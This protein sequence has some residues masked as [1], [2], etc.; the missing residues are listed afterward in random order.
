MRKIIVLGS[1]GMLGQMVKCFFEEKKFEVVCYDDRFTDDKFTGYVNFLNLQESSI[2]INCVG[3]I[4][5]KYDDS[6]SL[7]FANALLPL[8]LARSLKKDHF[9]VHPSTDCVFNGL[10]DSKYL[11]SAN[12]NAEDIYG[13]SKSLGEKAILS[14]PNSLI[15]R[16]SIIGTDSNSKSG[17]LS[18]FLNL[19]PNEV[20]R[21]FNNHYWNGITT[22]EWCEQL[23]DI[24]LKIKNFDKYETEII[25]LGTEKIYSKY[26]MLCLFQKIFETKYIIEKYTNSETINRTLVSDK[27]VIELEEQLNNLKYFSG[28]QNETF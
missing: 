21:G 6:M 3:R 12:H 19:S 22:L 24:L 7:L 14:R 4:K 18:W 1:K 2:I 9:L 23:L 20:L 11:K 27:R 17:L 28:L 26:E 25:Q 15:F 5:Q 10:S 13:W 16:V 8:E